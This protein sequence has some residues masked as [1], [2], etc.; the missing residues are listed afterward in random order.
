MRREPWWFSS[1]AWWQRAGALVVITA[2]TVVVLRLASEVVGLPKGYNS[3]QSESAV[4]LADHPG[5]LASWHSAVGRDLVVYIPIYVVV[6]SAVFWWV[7]SRPWLS[8]TL[9]VAAAIVD[10]VETT[11]FRGTLRHLID[12][13][14]AGELIDRTTATAMTTGVKWAFVGAAIVALGFAV[15]GRRQV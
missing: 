12:D 9:L 11:R 8:V 7:T 10:A 6:G 14:P 4:W 15:V 13:R 1:D 3:A 5:E 2:V